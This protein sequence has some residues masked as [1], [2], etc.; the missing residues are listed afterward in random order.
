VPLTG[1]GA[2][3]VRPVMN[4]TMVRQDSGLSNSDDA[5][6]TTTGG[7]RKKALNDELLSDPSAA[8]L[9]SKKPRNRVRS[10]RLLCGELSFFLTHTK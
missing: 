5:I 10:A 7:K 1:V 6:R 2:N 8:S 9:R 3:S 4:P